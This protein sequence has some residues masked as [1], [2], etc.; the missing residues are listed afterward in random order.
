MAD[1]FITCPSCGAPH[2][3]YNPGLAMFVCE[4][5]DNAV[6]W[7][8]GRIQDAGKQAVLP[9][10]FTRL[11]RGATG[12]LFQRRFC[13][14][15]RARYSYG[16]GFWDEWYLEMH[17][18]SVEWLTEDDGELSLQKQIDTPKDFSSRSP[19]VGAWLAVGDERF[20]VEEVGTAKCIGVEGDLPKVVTIGEEYRYADASSPDGRYNLSVEYDDTPPT[21]FR[22]H[23]LKYA[24]MRLDDEGDDW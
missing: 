21:L 15:G 3:I 12:S 10:G 14:L 9:E 5:C 13:V 24:A 16:E 22:G 4:Y 11:Y 6:Y 8:E 17:D 1:R 20:V 7:D 23:W 18:G 2:E 19:K